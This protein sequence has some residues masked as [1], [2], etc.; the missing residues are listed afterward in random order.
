ME[1]S[2]NKNNNDFK[3]ILPEFEDENSNDKE[4][5]KILEKEI[6]S[7]CSFNKYIDKLEI[8]NEFTDEELILN[9]TK[10]EIISYKNDQII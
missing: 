7:T 4:Y 1:K 8:I 3:Y 5:D 2:D 10:E 6:E 9:K